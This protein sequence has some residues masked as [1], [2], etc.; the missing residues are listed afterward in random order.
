MQVQNLA[1]SLNLCDF[2]L[3]LNKSSFKDLKTWK[4][5]KKYGGTSSHHIKRK[6]SKVLQTLKNSMG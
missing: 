4:T 2:F 1:Y 5:L 6:C 3:S